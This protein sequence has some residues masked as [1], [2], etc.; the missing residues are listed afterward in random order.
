MAWRSCSC[1]ETRRARH[2]HCGDTHRSIFGFWPVLMYCV[3]SLVQAYTRN[4]QNNTEKRRIS[5][6]MSYTGR[7]GGPTRPPACPPDCPPACPRLRSDLAGCAT[8][9]ALRQII[10]SCSR[11]RALPRKQN[12]RARWTKPSMSA[13]ATRL[14]PCRLMTLPSACLDRP[15]PPTTAT[16]RT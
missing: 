1:C 7:H 12:A 16:A 3:F 11:A 8:S 4:V 5:R 9:G 15:R 2:Q 6:L 10:A 14:C 13:T